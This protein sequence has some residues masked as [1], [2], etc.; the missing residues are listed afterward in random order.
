MWIFFKLVIVGI[1]VLVRLLAKFRPRRGEQFSS[2][3]VSG[4]LQ[5][6]SHKGRITSSTF[7]FS[8]KSP[9]IFK[10]SR[11]TK[12]DHFFKFLG[13]AQEVQTGDR[14]FDSEIYVAS[15]SPAFRHE[16]KTDGESRNF[17]KEIFQRG[18]LHVS[19]DGETISMHFNGEKRG[20]E[21]LL[22]L[23]A[24]LAKQL[25]DMDRAR[26]QYFRD[27]FTIKVLFLEA[28]V[29]SLAAYAL[30]GFFEFM[31]VKEDIHLYSK[32]LI[33]QGLLLG[34]VLAGGLFAIV[35]LFLHRSSRAH[36]V[37]VESF[38]LLMISLPICGI[39]F[40]RDA[41]IHFDKGPS[42]W[43]EAGIV[44]AYETEH[45]GRRGRKWYTYHLQVSPT[46]GSK[47][48]LLPPVIQVTQSVYSR[49]FTG[50]KVKIEIGRGWLNHP[51]YRSFQ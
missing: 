47:E 38:L 25:S 49:H 36:H 13:L 3:G 33:H 16:I 14:H 11:E 12:Y 43:A 50:S 31:M 51:W 29:W 46:S 32:P 37:L 17:I 4:L 7:H 40:I 9:S 5:T 21:D 45:R 8:F 39:D 42:V 18:C 28:F 2:Y 26:P 23:C 1:S 35:I 44:N 19:G 41:N 34:F 15:D 24:K 6:K 20:D 10:L 22:D 48:I 30:V 27:P